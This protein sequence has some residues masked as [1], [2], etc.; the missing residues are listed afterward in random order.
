MPD[1]GKRELT[2]RE[3]SARAR[4]MSCIRTRHTECQGQVYVNLFFDGTNNNQDW[5]GPFDEGQA[6]A[7][8]QQARNAHSNVARLYNASLDEPTNGFFRYYIPGVGTPFDKIGDVG[9]SLNLTSQ[10]RVVST[11]QGHALGA[12]VARYGERR[13]YWA[14]IQVLNSVY[15]YITSGT[16]FI[17]N[18]DA[19][20]LLLRWDAPQSIN[21]LVAALER[22]VQSAQLKLRTINVSVFGF[23]RGAAE[24]RACVNWLYAQAQST[25][26]GYTL[27]G[28]PLQVL[29]LGL[30]DT[31]ASVGLTS[32]SR[33]ANGRFSW[34][35]DDL[36]SIHPDVKKCV[37]FVAL[38]EQRINFPVDLI[39]TGKE[40][41]YPGVHSD[42]GGG[43]APGEQGKNAVNGGVD[44]TAKLSQ[45]PLVDMHYE[46]M[47]AG[48]TL[49]TQGE[50]ADDD[51]LRPQFACHPQLIQDYNAWLTGHGVAGGDNVAQIKGH[52]RQYVQWKSLRAAEGAQNE[53]QQP[54]YQHAGSADKKDLDNARDDF[55]RRLDTL[56]YHEEHPVMAGLNDAIQEGSFLGGL[57]AIS[58]NL[59]TPETRELLNLAMARSPLPDVVTRLLDGYVHDSLAS[60]K[61]EGH[62]EMDFPLLNTNGY[63]CYRATFSVPNAQQIKAAQEAD[64]QAR[65]LYPGAPS[66]GQVL[67]D[68]GSS[69]Q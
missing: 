66:A 21:K 33:V 67:G 51:E 42:V 27:A 39:T 41:L 22:V 47:K 14:I 57:N 5:P 37:H 34:A 26:S 58:D 48:V 56:K 31:V 35:S 43:Y 30:F 49:K 40:V 60:F 32:M 46:A 19:R 38:H 52:A 18:N 69:M 29:F 13:I 4:A 23:S 6:S 62:T 59:L 44:G 68:A 11:T 10:G 28:A 24:A 12:A 54:Y 1:E 63:L 53:A 50:I 3:I 15:R 65:G 8:T 64:M 55:S 2:P 20:T 9:A 17:N 7:Q 16:P 36:M 25:G 45:I 61:I